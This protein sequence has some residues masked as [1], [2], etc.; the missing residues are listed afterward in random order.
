MTNATTG[1]DLRALEVFVTVCETRSMTLAARQLGMTQ[2]A[3]S[4]A[5]KRLE[6]ATGAALIDR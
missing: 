2:P 1:L 4:Y 6:E 3:A 5:I